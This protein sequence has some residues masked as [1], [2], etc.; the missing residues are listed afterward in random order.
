MNDER[1]VI[2]KS[3]RKN[4]LERIVQTPEGV[5]LY[6]KSQ[7]NATSEH[8]VRWEPLNPQ[9]LNQQHKH[10]PKIHPEC[11][12]WSHRLRKMIYTFICI[13]VKL[14]TAGHPESLFCLGFLLLPFSPHLFYVHS[15]HTDQ[16]QIAAGSTKET[17]VLL[18]SFYRNWGPERVTDPKSHT[19]SDKARKLTSGNLTLQSTSLI[20]IIS[21]LVG[22]VLVKFWEWSIYY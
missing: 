11:Q 15:L 1:K 9:S 6:S 5:I 12:L 21:A 2:L 3:R 20:T 14:A 17:D 16:F 13:S 19:R 10:L 7:K 22:S 4:V 18:S 8:N